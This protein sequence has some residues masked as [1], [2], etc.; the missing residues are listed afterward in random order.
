ML[1]TTNENLKK[2]FTLIFLLL[3]KIFCDQSLL[4]ILETQKFT[5][6]KF[7]G[8]KKLALAALIFV[9]KESLKI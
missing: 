2:F 7:G 1:I 4:P 8:A 3:R 6:Q 5:T 9:E